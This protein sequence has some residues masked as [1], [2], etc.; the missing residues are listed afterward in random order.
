VLYWITR[1]W[2][3]AHRGELHDDPVVFALKDRMSYVL[4]AFAAVLLAAATLL[5]GRVPI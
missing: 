2:L 3:I 5:H 1:V 4:G